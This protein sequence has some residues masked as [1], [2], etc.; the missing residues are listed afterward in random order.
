MAKPSPGGYPAAMT[1]TSRPRSAVAVKAL[2]R[3]FDP[4]GLA[5]LAWSGAFIAL[6]AVL[7]LTVR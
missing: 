1:T 7:A 4:M 6:T 5:C 2:P 3:P